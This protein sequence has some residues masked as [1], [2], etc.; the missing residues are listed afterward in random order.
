MTPLSKDE[1][2]HLAR[3]LRRERSFAWLLWV[4]LGAG[5]LLSAYYT[6]SGSWSGLRLV[7]VMLIL[8]GAR[9]HLRQL[10]SV[11]LLR[12]LAGPPEVREPV[13]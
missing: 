4:D 3:M 12:R 6:W 5:V 10:R 2:R 11:R 13:V 9:S 7:V 8:L 1:A